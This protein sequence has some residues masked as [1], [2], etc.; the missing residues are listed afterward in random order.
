MFRDRGQAPQ[1]GVYDLVNGLIARD[2]SAF[3]RGGAAYYTTTDFGSVPL[4]MVWAGY[5]D[6]LT[7]LLA[8]NST[9][10]AVAALDDR[11]LTPIGGPGLT[12]PVKPVTVGR[13]LI[14]PGGIVYAGALHGSTYS[15]GTISIPA[16][17]T[18]V[19][20]AGTS[21]L[22][23]AN[24]W[25]FL[26]V[27]GHAPAQIS[28]VESDTILHLRDYWDATA[29]TGSSYTISTF[30]Q[31]PTWTSTSGAIKFGKAAPYYAVAGE[32][33]VACSGNRAHMS[34]RN[35]PF[36]FDPTDYHELPGG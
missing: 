4:R 9:G 35:D 24:T 5:V 8:A 32:R 23:N 31:M 26:N 1:N 25:M 21:W 7:R 12:A 13:L 17:S 18:D 27:T 6:N 22:A 14:F 36:T 16:G 2:G 29:V 3:K 28:T 33:L 30:A 15:T 11:A 20:G 34:L 10:F 19:T